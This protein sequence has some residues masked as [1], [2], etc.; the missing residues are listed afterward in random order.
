VRASP[1]RPQLASLPVGVWTVEILGIGLVVGAGFADGYTQAVGSAVGVALMLAVPLGVVQ[2]ILEERLAARIEQ[3]VSESVTAAASKRLSGPEVPMVPEELDLW[4]FVALV[5]PQP[6]SQVRLCLR[7]NGSALESVQPIEVMIVVTDPADRTFSTDRK[8]QS[9]VG[10][11]VAEW[12]WPDNFTSGDTREGR[13]AVE[14]FVA[15]LSAGPARRFGLVATSTFVYSA[16]GGGSS[17]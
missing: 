6:D 9:M 14:F 11:D 4:P 16:S 12:I 8:L 13:H 17:P 15:P 7:S 10:Q 3:A 5:E 1:S 2:R